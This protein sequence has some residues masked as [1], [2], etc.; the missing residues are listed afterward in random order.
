MFVVCRLVRPRRNR[1]HAAGSYRDY[2]Q[3]TPLFS[4][5]ASSACFPAG[6][7]VRQSQPRAPTKIDSL[8]HVFVQRITCF[9]CCIA[10]GCKPLDIIGKTLAVHPQ[11]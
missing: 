2:W 3:P 6:L 7:P 11:P 9:S 8:R 1:P 10:T 5:D 4:P